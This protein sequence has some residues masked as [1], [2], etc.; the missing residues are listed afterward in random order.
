MFPLRDVIPSRTT[1]VVTVI[2]IALNVLAFL[3]EQSLGPRGL[4]EF[5]RAYGFVP[6]Q[7]AWVTILSSMFLHGSWFHLGGNMWSLWIFGDNVE[8]RLGHAR[9]LGFYLLCGVLATLAHAWSNPASLVPTVGASGAIA[10]IMGA[11]FVLYPH[12][13]VLTLIFIVFYVNIVEIPAVV[14]L[15]FWFLMQ[16]VSGVGS[17]AASSTEAGGIAF[18]AH[19]AGFAVGAGLVKL[20]ARPQSP[21]WYDAPDT[22]RWRG[23]WDR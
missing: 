18:W 15:G 2:I 14:F 17:L 6:A 21:E 8:D 12:S 3:F 9:Y 13:R 22:Q 4:D 11:Y 10:G 23:E 16:L 5:I 7:F 20:L 1:P 19:V